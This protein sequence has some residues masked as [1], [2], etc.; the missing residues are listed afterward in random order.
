MAQVPLGGPTGGIFIPGNASG[1]FPSVPVEGPPVTD[2]P[3]SGE[4]VSVFTQTLSD[5]NRIHREDR[6]LTFRDRAG[7]TRR[8]EMVNGRMTI[9]INDPVAGVHYILDPEQR[10]GQM[11]PIPMGG[12]RREMPSDIANSIGVRVQIP[13][14]MI[15]AGLNGTQPGDPTETIE[16]DLGAR[17]IEGINALGTR[18]T[19]ILPAAAFHA[20]RDIELTFER[21]RSEE[22]Q[23]DLERIRKD[24][25]GG[26]TTYRLTDINRS[27]PL[28]S[29]FEPPPD[30][31]VE[32]V[33]GRDRVLR[34]APWQIQSAP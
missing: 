8:E 19:T 10:T 23:L 24:P 31:Q 25:R 12:S 18:S 34:N 16:E 13:A 17:T 22:L 6:V 28:P 32:D 15:R 5:G 14:A 9:R 11:L 29:L 3:Y 33:T 2:A 20:E 1:S 21:W 7:R 27:E 30:F 4:A 26:E